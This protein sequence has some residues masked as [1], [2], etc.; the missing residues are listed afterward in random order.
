MKKN[1]L[2][3]S[4]VGNE[5]IY[6]PVRSKLG[7]KSHQQYLKVAYNSTQK[8]S[9]IHACYRIRNHSDT[10]SEAQ[11]TQCTESQEDQDQGMKL[12]ILTQNIIDLCLIVQSMHLILHLYHFNCRSR[13]FQKSCWCSCN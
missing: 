1:H 2:Q 7:R 5:Y 11:H 8:Y 13:F 3:T 12:R 10:S 4:I 6:R 9:I